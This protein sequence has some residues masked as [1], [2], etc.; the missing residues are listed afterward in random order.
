MFEKI[1]D[2][3]PDAYTRHARWYPCVLV[4]LPI[5]VLI[6]TVAI[7]YIDAPGYE[8]VKNI[9]SIIL[10][11]S[12]AVGAAIKFLAGTIRDRGKMLEEREFKK[13]TAFPTTEFLLWDN[14]EFTDEYKRSIRNAIREDFGKVLL[15]A[16]AERENEEHARRLIAEAVDVIRPRIKD[17]VRLLQY[18]IR[19]GF[20]RNL[21]AGSRD[22]GLPCALV[23]LF[24]SLCWL[25][26]RACA[27]L[28]VILTFFYLWKVI[29]TEENM[30]WYGE[31]YARV[32][33]AEYMESRA[34]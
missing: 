8:L 16:D 26:N 7:F 32:M 9:A 20:A 12:F 13:R 21:A 27:V 24:L 1:G 31:E 6:A 17:G 11:V 18:N 22:I 25:D 14:N 2:L 15:D 33:F 3:F 4:S 34:R 19:Y 23:C 10:S 28:E 5:A 29:K 30:K